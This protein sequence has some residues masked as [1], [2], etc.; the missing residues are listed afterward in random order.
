M[1]KSVLMIGLLMACSVVT[2]ASDNVFEVKDGDYQKSPY[3]GMDR[4]HWVEAGKYLLRGAF[5]YIHCLNDPMYFP[6]QL[7]KTYPHNEAEAKVAKLEGLARTLFL[8]STLLRD[9]PTLEMNGISV[10]EYYRYQLMAISNPDSK[11]YVP[12]HTVGPSQTLIELG[13]I[14]ISLKIAEDVL[15]TPLPQEGKDKLIATLKGYGEGPTIDSNWMFFNVFIMSFMKEKGYETDD[16]L[17]ED[18]LRKLL[19]RYRGEG[20]YNDN[21]AYDYYSMWAYQVYGPLWAHWFG[22]MFPDI[23]Q[24]YVDN[25][26]DL[27]ANYPY[28]FSRDGK[29]NM[30]GRSLPYRFVSTA[31]FPILEYADFDDV[32]YGW[33]RRIASSTL[34]QFLTHPD[35]LENGVPTMGFYGPFAPCVQIYSCRGSVFWIGKAFLGLMLPENSKYWS[36]TE[37]M[38]PWED[39]LLEGNVYDKFQPATNLMITNYPNSGASEIRSWCHERVA[40]DWQQFRSSENYNKLAYN[41]EFPW[42]ADGPNGEVSMNYATLNAMGEWEVLRLY[43]FLSYDGGVYRRDAVLETDSSVVYQLADI[44][45]PDGILRVDKIHV[46]KPTPIS[47]GHYSLPEGSPY[48]LLLQPLHGWKSSPVELHPSNLHPMTKTC[49]LPIL[50]DTVE[51][52]TILITLMLWKK[53]DSLPKSPVSNIE[54]SDD[55]NHVTIT[56][57]DGT[58]RM[59]TYITDNL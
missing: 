41:T 27:V 14:A 36:S 59:V 10:A 9:D 28:M 43:D 18:L 58:K 56:L 40:D 12:Q 34:L 11:H 1:K 48:H 50:R 44:T 38:G 22:Y 23:A 5:G 57:N 47:L 31:P 3:T 25:E 39:E 4:S 35:F 29:M 30:W 6:R 33:L 21:P 53:G 7:D 51:N 54:I 17:L 32:D 45:L 19:A 55:N 24:Q 37:T 8:A 46:S 42:M 2:E 52:N 20:W 49:T 16:T 13:S 15:W 26:H